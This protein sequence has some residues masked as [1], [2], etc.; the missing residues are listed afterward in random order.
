M[1]QVIG[2]PFTPAIVCPGGL[3]QVFTGTR[4]FVHV[5]L[6]AGLSSFQNV[7]ANAGI[8]SISH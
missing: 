8:F 6:L 5:N 2:N 3:S 1:Q 7:L 4:S